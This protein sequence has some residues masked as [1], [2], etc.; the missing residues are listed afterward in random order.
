MAF[1][2]SSQC[3]TSI[4]AELL[5][6]VT[7]AMS[8]PPHRPVKSFIDF[9]E[10]NETYEQLTKSDFLLRARHSGQVRANEFTCRSKEISSTI[11]AC[12]LDDPFPI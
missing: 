3:L 12:D 8:A 1:F 9:P 11:N 5:S 7:V 4:S 2:L 10:L 6:C